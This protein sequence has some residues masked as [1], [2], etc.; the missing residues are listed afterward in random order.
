MTKKEAVRRGKLL[1]KKMKTKGW[2]LDVWENLGWR[3]C[4][5]KPSIK[6][7]PFITNNMDM[8]AIIKY[9]GLIQPNY[10]FWTNRAGWREDPNEAADVALKYARKIATLHNGILDE[11]QNSIDSDK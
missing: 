8:N 6:I 9:H 3:Y 5:S 2:K 10:T 4:I 7:Y 1:L 11:A